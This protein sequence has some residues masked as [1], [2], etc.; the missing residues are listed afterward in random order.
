MQLQIKISG[1][2]NKNIKLRQFEVI[3][4]S[5]DRKPRLVLVPG[6][7]EAP[8]RTRP[9]L[10]VLPVTPVKQ[11]QT[12]FFALQVSSGR[13]R[14]RAWMSSR[15]QHGRG[16]RNRKSAVR[17]GCVCELWCCWLQSPTRPHPSTP[18]GA[19]R[20]DRGG[21]SINTKERNQVFVTR[22]AG[23]HRKGWRWG[24]VSSC[25]WV[26]A[27]PGGGPGGHSRGWGSA[28]TS[29]GA[30]TGGGDTG[31]GDTG[32]ADTGGADTGGLPLV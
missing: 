27:P 31:E 24:S 4:S 28:C 1:G 7:K 10:P 20:H 32:G 23:D 26:E 21:C 30:D 15:S 12:H 6:P 25:C 29:A 22:S 3:R 8:Q 18:P 5:D 13:R 14:R 17:R 19:A 2:K 16:I 11:T 9:V